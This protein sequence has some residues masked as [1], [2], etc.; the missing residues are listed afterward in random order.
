MRLAR[1]WRWCA[2]AAGTIAC[3]VF[4]QRVWAGG[5]PETAA[6]N[7][8]GT[9][10]DSSGNPLK[11]D[12][13]VQLTFWRAKEMAASQL[14]CQ[15]RSTTVDLR[16]SGQFSITLPEE[17]TQAVHD[18]AELWVEVTVDGSSLGPA[19]LG[20]V[21]YALEAK[22]A[23]SADDVRTGTPLEGRLKALVPPKSILG[24][25]LSADDIAAS[26]DETGL[27]K[28][29][30]SYAGWAICNGENGTPNLDGRFPRM[31]TMAAGAVGGNDN[32]D[33]T[34]SINHDHP[35]FNSGSEAAHTHQTPAHQ[36]L[37]PIGFDGSNQFW[38]AGSDGGPRYGSTVFSA[39]R[40]APGIGDWQDNLARLAYT[41]TVP[42]TPTSAG[43]AHAHS[44]D[45]PPL[46]A[47]SGEASATD[48]RPAFVELVPLMRL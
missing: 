22:H 15:T 9:L 35:A 11:G 16:S 1:R 12:H 14:A 39:P 26:F 45:P 20:A 33:H 34:H 36:H 3:A 46:A 31:S 41:E 44:I 4:G 27:G 37:M 24:A 28:S 8:A 25:Y 5:V 43:T 17:C 38:V 40:T 30:S 10:Q 19:R 23:S 29:D 48:N 42:Q 32:S 2:F 6:L 13:N 21:P 18:N 47:T 7:Y